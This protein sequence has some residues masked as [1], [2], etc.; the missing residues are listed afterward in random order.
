MKKNVT[1]VPVEEVMEMLIFLGRFRWMDA[2]EACRI[3]EDPTITPESSVFKTV[4]EEIFDI[5]HHA[6]DFATLY[7][8]EKYNFPRYIRKELLAKPFFLMAGNQL[9]VGEAPNSQDKYYPCVGNA[10][11]FEFDSHTEPADNECLFK[12]Y[13]SKDSGIY[14]KSAPGMIETWES[15][16]LRK[17]PKKY[18][19]V[20]EKATTTEEKRTK[21][22]CLK[23]VP[24]DQ[25]LRYLTAIGRYSHRWHNPQAIPEEIFW[26]ASSNVDGNSDDFA[27]W[28][29]PEK[30]GLPTYIRKELK[31]KPYF[32][33]VNNKILVGN[34]CGHEKGYPCVGNARGY[35]FDSYTEPAD[36]ECLFKI[37]F[38]ESSG[39]YFKSAPGMIETWDT[40]G[41]LTVPNR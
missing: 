30:H 8:P 9:L 41:L 27:V 20:I 3:L 22:N 37:F 25:V 10:K 26:S 38:D 12:I 2:S 21:K 7:D 17:I 36:N 18:F 31:D 35:E 16:G 14:F 11:G 24:T 1:T 33:M 4:P 40:A 6:H 28:Y 19:C 5:Y 34:C 32:L 13:F 15:A 23:T 29:N 39:I